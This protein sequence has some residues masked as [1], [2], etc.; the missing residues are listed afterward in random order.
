MEF[1]EI[2]AELEAGK[3]IKITS[4]EKAYWHKV[5]N[6]IVYHRENGSECPITAIS[7]SAEFWNWVLNGEWDI[8]DDNVEC[9]GFGEAMQHLNR[10]KKIAR[11]AW[12]SIGQYLQKATDIFYKNASCEIVHCNRDAV[13]CVNETCVLVGWVATQADM[14]A[15]DWMIV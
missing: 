14:L 11:R 1:H 15:D 8:A 13:S 12:K 10:G 7:D 9:F 3:K 2:A 5:G 4:W 6:R